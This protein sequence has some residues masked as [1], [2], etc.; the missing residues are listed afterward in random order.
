MTEKLNTMFDVPT[1]EDGTTNARSLNGTAQLTNT[2]TV[3]ANAILTAVNDDFEKFEENFTKSKTEHNAMDKLIAE[4]HDLSAV[5]VE[6]L[7]AIEEDTLEGML[8][9]QQSKR[10]RSKGKVM[11][12]DN[13]KVLMIG[14]IAEGILWIVLDKPKSAVGNRHAAGKVV[15]TDED[16][17]A[18]AD[19]Q[20]RLRK[21][22]RNVQS[23][24]SIM[25]SKEGFSEE[26]ERWQALLLAEER[27][28]G[29]R[30]DAVKTIIIDDTKNALTSMFDGVDTDNM[31][32]A[33]VRDMLA[34][35]K[36][37]IAESEV[38]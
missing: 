36:S 2:S 31:K 10:S 21:E 23:K 24:K 20:E 38:Q 8:K 16:L 22:I 25:K 18:L 5:D 19:D 17:V 12:M 3:V 34:K 29:V 9:S 37:L 32:A 26:D 30:A 15:F 11:T 28:K 33:E 4:T 27:L 1:A 13:Y 7:R 6:F 14:A 35:A